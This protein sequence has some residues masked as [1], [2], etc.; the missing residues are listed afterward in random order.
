MITYFL[1]YGKHVMLCFV[2][3]PPGLKTGVENE[4]FWSEIW[5]GFGESGGTPQGVA[6]WV[7]Y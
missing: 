4:I 5:S 2:I 1:F 6:P 3:P 7:Q